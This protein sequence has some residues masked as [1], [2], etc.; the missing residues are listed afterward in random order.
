[1]YSQNDEEKV[2]LDFLKT[3]RG[4]FLDI[5][6]CDGIYVSNTR[7]LLEIGWGGV[8]VE[9]RAES[10]HKLFDNCAPFF[11][12][13]SLIQAA[14]SNAEGLKRFWIDMHPNREWSA[15]VN[16][17]LLGIGSV[18]EPSPLPVYIPCI[19]T[20]ELCQFGPFDFISI[21]AE[22]EDF[23]I[24]KSSPKRFWIGCKLLCVESRHQLERIEMKAYLKSIGFTRIIHE[25]KE[26]L[27]V[28]PL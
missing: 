19:T 2:I 26:N 16:K 23:A 7:K 22:W 14:V 10:F 17:A 24:L 1:M 3:D 9:P 8:L 20:D 15:T 21:D 5:G 13:V 27:L 11:D 18:I 25:T 4:R 12:R 6:A 28:T